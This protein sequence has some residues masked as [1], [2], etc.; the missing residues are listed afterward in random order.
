MQEW[1]NECPQQSSLPWNSI[2]VRQI[3]QLVAFAVNLVDFL[4]IITMAVVSAAEINLLMGFRGSESTADPEST[5]AVPRR[6]T[7][8]I[9]QTTL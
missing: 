3:L 6:P 5:G 8:N 9:K 1:Q 7:E 2:C 4:C